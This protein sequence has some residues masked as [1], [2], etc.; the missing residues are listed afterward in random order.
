[1][2]EKRFTTKDKND[3]ELDIV[4]KKPTNRQ[5][6]QSEKQYKQAFRDA[7]EGGAILRKKLS[8]YMREQGIWTDEQEKQYEKVIKEINALDYQLNSGK[9]LDGKKLKVSGGKEIA[10]ELSDK[11][12]EF[13][14][15]ISERQE[16]D[17]VTAEG[18]ADA[19]KYNYLVYL[20]T[21]DFLTQ[22][23][24]FSSYEEYQDRGN[25]EVAIRA[26]QEIGEIVYEIDPEYESSLTENKFLKRFKLADEKNRLV[27]TDGDFVDRDGGRLDG[28]G[29]IL[30]D[31]GKR[32]NINDLP[33]LEENE[34]VD[35]VDFEDDV[36][37]A[38][39]TKKRSTKKRPVNQEE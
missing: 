22:K 36:N 28:E 1:M 23:P 30:N 26:S 4:V 20:C 18:Q 10:F 15:L 6:I 21:Y 12:V 9:D 25:E 24:Y 37:V 38:K 8:V 32:V 7:L 31:Q 19:E 39:A 33:I 3:K 27:N 2:D 14:D 16:L 34:N 29:Y 11:R 35:A 5:L 17:Y 13:R